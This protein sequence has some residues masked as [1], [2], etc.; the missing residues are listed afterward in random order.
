MPNVPPGSIFP[1]QIDTP[2]SLPKRTDNISPINAAAINILRNAIVGIES[3][4]GVDAQG[5]YGSIRARLDALEAAIGGGGGGGGFSPGGDLSGTSTHQRVIGLYDVPL[6]SQT[7]LTNQFLGF[8]GL[9]WGATTIQSNQIAPS[10]EIT[11]SGPTLVEV[12][13]TVFNPLFTASY[14]FTPTTATFVDDQGSPSLDVLA[15]PSP[16]TQNEFFYGTVSVPNQYQFNTYGATVLFTLTSTSGTSTALATNTLTWTQNVYYGAAVA[17]GSFTA[18]FI[19]S[20]P[21]SYLALSRATTFTVLASTGQSIFYAYRA[22]Y[23]GGGGPS[24]WAFGWSGGMSLAATV[25]V[26]NDQGF[27]EDYNIYQSDY[28]NLGLT[29]VSVF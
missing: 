29:T 6:S 3:N 23:D 10:Y 24:F 1:A 8:N 22:A 20:L 12:G 18:A 17:P 28:T 4:I 9:Y 13:F 14:S 7:P 21:N 2:Q 19:Q 16:S 26:T 25:S 27:T 5:V 11:L 15:P